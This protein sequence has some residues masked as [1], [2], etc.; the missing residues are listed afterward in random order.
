MNLHFDANFIVFALL[1]TMLASFVIAWAVGVFHSF[2]MPNASFAPYVL[3]V[4]W[5]VCTY[6]IGVWIL[7]MWHMLQYGWTLK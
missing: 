5:G 3:L 1:V 2:R 4:L 7:D 6:F